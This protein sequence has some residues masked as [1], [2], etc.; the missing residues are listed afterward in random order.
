MTVGEFIAA[1]IVKQ[2]GENTPIGYLAQH[3]LLEQVYIQVSPNSLSC[4][5]NIVKVQSARWQTV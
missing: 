2:M 1:H 4:I 5:T 3:P